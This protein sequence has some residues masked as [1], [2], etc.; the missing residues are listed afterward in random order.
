MDYKMNY[1]EKKVELEKKIDDLQ[2]EYFSL[3]TGIKKD[4]TPLGDEYH[5]TKFIYKWERLKELQK[6]IITKENIHREICFKIARD[7]LE[8]AFTPTIK[9]ML[10]ERIT[11]EIEK[12]SDGQI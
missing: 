7:S 3:I 11:N 4:G 10:D 1:E 6:E 12:D 8:R 2:N 9:K 5:K